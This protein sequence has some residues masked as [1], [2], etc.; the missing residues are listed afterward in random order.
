M[1]KVMPKKPSNY[2]YIEER[3]GVLC[4]YIYR[5]SLSLVSFI[6]TGGV[7]GCHIPCEMTK[8]FFPF[9]FIALD[10]R[11]RVTKVCDEMRLPSTLCCNMF[12]S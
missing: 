10:F 7:R 12:G 3:G 5:V 9:V 11:T 8:V 4:H 2:I 1:T 6:Y